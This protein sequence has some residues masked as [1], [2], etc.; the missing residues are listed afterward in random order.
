MN[1]P[2]TTDGASGATA[3]RR[4]VVLYACI[5][6]SGRSVAGLYLTRH[7]AGE[8]VDA[9]SA[10]S[11]PGTEVN[12]Q[13]AR[14]LAE[15]GIPVD[16]HKPSLLTYDGVAESDVVITMGCGEACPAVPGKRI[17]DWELEDPKGKDLDTVRRIVDDIDSRVLALLS[18]LAVDVARREEAPGTRGYG[19]PPPG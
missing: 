12:P 14:V 18:D 9:R 13:I 15:R 3:S 17:I 7:H 16:D 5:H 1:D 11:E 8:R 19:G 2:D 4:P 6:N 10:G